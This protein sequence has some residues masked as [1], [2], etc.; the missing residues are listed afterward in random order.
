M[1]IVGYLKS[2]YLNFIIFLFL[3]RCLAEFD[4]I[5]FFVVPLILFF[6]FV[7]LHP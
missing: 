3:I 7:L 4:F 1:S 6:I 5:L 2:F